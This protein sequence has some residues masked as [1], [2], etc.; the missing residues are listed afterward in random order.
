MFFVV[1]H[2]FK[3]IFLPYRRYNMDQ[4]TFPFILSQDMNIATDYD[5][6]KS[7]DQQNHRVIDS[8]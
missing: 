3:G 5:Y 1:R 7:R 4:V 6:E 2:P 8:R